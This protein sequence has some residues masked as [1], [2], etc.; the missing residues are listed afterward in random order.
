MIRS[1][2]RRLLAGTVAGTLAVVL[3]AGAIVYGV[4]RGVLRQTFDDALVAKARSLASIVECEDDQYEFE[5]DERTLPEFN[6]TDNPEYFEIRQ[7]SGPVIA[8][9][10]SLQGGTLAPPPHASPLVTADLTLPDGRRGRAAWVETVARTDSRPSAAPPIQ[11]V[12]ARDTADLEHRLAALTR[13]LVVIAAAVL[14]LVALLLRWVVSGGLAPLD[15]LASQIAALD[16]DNLST[17]ITLPDAPTELAPVVDVCNQLLTRLEGVVN[18]ER[19]FASD[20]AHELRTPLAGIRS[21]LEVAASRDRDPAAYR[22]AISECVGIAVQMQGMTDNLL[23]LARLEREEI[24]IRPAPVELD[25]VLQD[26]WKPLESGASERNVRVEWATDPALVVATDRDMLR[27]VVFNVLENAVTYVDTGGQIRITTAAENG[28][29]RLHVANTGSRVA[30]PD[31]DRVFDR[32]WRGD[33]ARS[34]QGLHVGLGLPLARR[35]TRALGGRIDAASE[36]GGLFEVTLHIPLGACAA[37][38]SIG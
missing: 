4:T 31:A 21:L 30:R 1:I 12:V 10:R 27:Q 35:L 24:R 15:R 19:S 13:W 38:G 8:R 5:I 25:G 26:A 34:G 36:A 29:A 22:T 23:A 18:R 37:T 32:F 28:A 11:V 6:R 3:I 2:R 33:G 7:A 20:V 9:S 16:A 14:A 17:R